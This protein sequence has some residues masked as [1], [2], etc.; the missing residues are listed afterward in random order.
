MNLVNRYG[1]DGQTDGHVNHL[2]SPPD[3]A[4]SFGQH[5]ELANTMAFGTASQADSSNMQYD[6]RKY[7]D[8]EQGTIKLKGAL[9]NSS[10]K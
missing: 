4:D 8:I 1:G 5:N 6:L 10:Q 2:G 7:G 3:H 9:E